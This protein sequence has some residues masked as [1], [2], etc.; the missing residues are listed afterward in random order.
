MRAV[1]I[2]VSAILVSIGVSWLIYSF[3]N[4]PN[5]A[6]QLVAPIEKMLSSTLAGE[7]ICSTGDAGYGIDNT[8]PWYQVFYLVDNTDV[9]QKIINASHT[10]G[11]PITKSEEVYAYYDNPANYKP[12]LNPD[13]PYIERLQASMLLTG[14]EQSSRYYASYEISKELRIDSISTPE[15][16]VRIDTQNGADT[17]CIGDR[18][19]FKHIDI[20]EGKAMVGLHVHMPSVR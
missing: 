19:K 16:E 8:F 1:L 5:K 4:P 18:N 11:V 2:I 10:I 14:Y 3:I 13:K 20:P 17:T 7:H 15:L 12:G 6:Q 9:D